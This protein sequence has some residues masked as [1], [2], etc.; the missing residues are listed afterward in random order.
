[1]TLQNDLLQIKTNGNELI[2]KNGQSIG[3]NT[4]VKTTYLCKPATE[5]HFI[6]VLSFNNGAVLFIMSTL[7][8]AA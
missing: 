1:M 3:V 4:A 6:R 8:A 7:K 5:N 2:K